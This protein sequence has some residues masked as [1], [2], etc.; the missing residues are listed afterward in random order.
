MANTVFANARGVAHKGSGGMSPVFPDVCLTPQAGGPSP[1]VPIPYPNIASPTASKGVRG[2]QLRAK[3]QHLH[4]QIGMLP[5][6][7][8]MR[9]HKLLDEYVARTAELYKTLSE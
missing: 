1:F 6:G 4:M 8:P 9:W 3:L 5:T 2:Q 7:D